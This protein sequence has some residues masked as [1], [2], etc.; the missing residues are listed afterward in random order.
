MVKYI[1]REELTT[2]IKAG[3]KL[4]YAALN[5]RHDYIVKLSVN[6]PLSRPIRDVTNE[7]H[8]WNRQFLRVFAKGVS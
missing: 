1:T 8:H 3:R 7:K 4:V 2:M 5:D 6:P